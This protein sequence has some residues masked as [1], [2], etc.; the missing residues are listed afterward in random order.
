MPKAN[1]G[2]RLLNL[3]DAASYYAFAYNRGVEHGRRM[4]QARIME[5]LKAEEVVHWRT[6]EKLIK[7]KK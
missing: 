7:D 6:A 5:I 4:E 2:K 3:P 1:R